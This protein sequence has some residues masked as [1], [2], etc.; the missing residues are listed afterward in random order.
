MS[1]ARNAVKRAPI[2][3]P[4]TSVPSSCEISVR[5]RH[6][7]RCRRRRALTVSPSVT[8]RPRL[9]DDPLNPHVTTAMAGRDG[10]TCRHPDRVVAAEPV[11]QND[12]ARPPRSTAAVRSSRLGC[13]HVD[14]TARRGSVDAS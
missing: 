7:V 11:A 12:V 4:T 1:A 14:V 3:A 10:V 13:D 2:D 5:N 6:Q 8:R 9:P